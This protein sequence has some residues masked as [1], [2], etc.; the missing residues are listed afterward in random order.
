MSQKTEHLA[1][2]EALVE[3]FNQHDL[4]KIME[5]FAEECSLDMPR[6]SKPWGTRYVGKAAVR[7]GL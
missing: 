2:L 4:D 1:M 6:G 3:A 5:S 7:R